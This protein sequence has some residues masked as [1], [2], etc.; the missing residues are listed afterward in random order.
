MNRRA[1][2]LLSIAVAISP[3][4][5]TGCLTETVQ[6]VGVPYR[7]GGDEFCL[8]ARLEDEDGDAIARLAAAALSESGEG[9]TVGCSYGCVHLPKDA[10]TASEALRLADIRMYEQK[11]SERRS[12]GRQCLGVQRI[13]LARLLEPSATML[14]LP[15]TAA[16][17]AS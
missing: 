12:A 1:S 4:A 13:N 14:P 8:L 16:L 9:F 7:M 6:G 17:P 3:V 15:G 2:L 5:L 10:S 11:A